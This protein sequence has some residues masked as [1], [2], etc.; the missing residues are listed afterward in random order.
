L[1]DVLSGAADLIRAYE[2]IASKVFLQRPF[3]VDAIRR[4]R[5]PFGAATPAG[6]KACAT[7]IDVG[8][9]EG[10]RYRNRRWQA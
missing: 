3:R 9:P 1:P 2:E 6:L 5:K 4:Q 10:L 7:G 8:R